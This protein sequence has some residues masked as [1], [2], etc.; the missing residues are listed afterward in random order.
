MIIF[1]QETRSMGLLKALLAIALGIFMIVTNANAMTLIVQ[2]ASACMLVAGL[3]PLFFRGNSASVVGDLSSA[4]YKILIAVLLFVFADP[5]AGI[6]RYLLGGLLCLFAV[7]SII[8]LIGA[9][10]SH[11]AGALAYVFPA[12][13]LL[14]GVL[15]FS[16][17]IV[18]KDI[19]GQIAGG[20]FVLYGISKGLTALKQ[21]D[22]K[23][24]NPYEDDSVDEQ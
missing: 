3:L 15:L 4:G 7:S 16:E 11:R 14:I 10:G 2:V 23:S 13:I 18:G 8:N 12:I 6:I 21:G 19:L 9:Q 1:R 17:E 5:V 22:P 20:A 24:S